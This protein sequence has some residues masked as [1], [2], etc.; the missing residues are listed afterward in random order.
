MRIAD[1]QLF[2]YFLGLSYQ[3]ISWDCYEEISL[4][5]R[6]IEEQPNETR[7]VSQRGNHI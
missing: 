4:I 2:W 5:G 3:T 1:A 6:C 7:R